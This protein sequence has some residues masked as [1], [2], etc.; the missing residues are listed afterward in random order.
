[1]N[2]RIPYLA[3]AS[4]YRGYFA[5]AAPTPAKGRYNRTLI[6][7]SQGPAMLTVPVSGGATVVKRRPPE[8]W[9][10]ADDKPWRHIH[11]GALNAAYGRTP[12]WRH[13]APEILDTIAD[14]SLT[15]FA[16]IAG[17]LH[18]LVLSVLRADEFRKAVVTDDDRR[19]VLQVAREKENEVRE[20]AAML[21][22]LFRLGPDA[23]FFLANELL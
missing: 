14:A 19:R 22:A 17:R 9:L 1:M 21:D 8:E 4:W 15:Q 5:G 10:V 16:D 18:E 20:E 12:F 13:Y 3:S 6:V 7:S 2:V 11:A 23:I